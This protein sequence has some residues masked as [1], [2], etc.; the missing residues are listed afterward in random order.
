MLTTV[1][2]LRA[3]LRARADDDDGAGLVEYA[4][5]AALIAMVCIL[6]VTFLGKATSSK[7]STIGQSVTAAGT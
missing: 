3:W 1:D 4:L 7:F 2:F 6:A 5:L